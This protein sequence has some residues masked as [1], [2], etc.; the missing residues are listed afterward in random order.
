[1]I[2]GHLCST[3]R[4]LPFLVCF[5]NCSPMV[6]PSI[7]NHFP[8]E[9]SVSATSSAD[10]RY[11]V[12]ESSRRCYR[13]VMQALDSCTDIDV[14]KVNYR[15]HE[16]RLILHID[17]P[18]E[19]ERLRQTLQHCGTMYERTH[20]LGRCVTTASFHS[21]RFSKEGNELFSL[22]MKAAVNEC[23]YLRFKDS[24]FISLLDL[25]IMEHVKTGIH[26]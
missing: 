9:K 19:R 12:N 13:E 24:H 5:S 18:S 11:A 25:F 10:Y 16:E 4:A 6:S 7:K 22:S 3:I 20:R 26:S 21:V 15:T 23:Y 2:Q 1:M 17:S 14:Y 8:A